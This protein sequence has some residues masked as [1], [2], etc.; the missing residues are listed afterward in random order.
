MCIWDLYCVFEVE[1]L[2]SQ[3]FLCV[4][5]LLSLSAQWWRVSQTVSPSR[6]MASS[7]L[8]FTG[9]A[10]F[11]LLNL[12][13]Y[14]KLNMWSNMFLIKYQTFKLSNLLWQKCLA[15]M[16]CSMVVYLTSDRFR[17]DTFCKDQHPSPFST[18]TPF[19]SLHFALWAIHTQ[20]C[21]QVVIAF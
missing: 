16:I 5:P 19:P 15:H 4:Q 13:G 6:V 14:F 18:G 17:A 9:S 8:C 3:R 2:Y 12:G 10:Y 11:K 20:L 7:E 21:T 1:A